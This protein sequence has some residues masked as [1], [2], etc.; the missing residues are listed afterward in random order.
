MPHLTTLHGRLDLPDLVPLYRQF[1]DIPLV[2]ISNAQRAPLPW[3]DWQGTVY[4]G[5]PL[6]QYECKKN[7]GSYLAFVGRFPEKRVD[8]AIEIAKCQYEAE[9]RRQGG[10]HRSPIY[11]KRDRPVDDPLVEFVGEIGERES[12]SF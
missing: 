2:S 3:V 5:L 1:A 12:Q 6:D 10:R 8:R 7:Q 4:H 9:D 11:G